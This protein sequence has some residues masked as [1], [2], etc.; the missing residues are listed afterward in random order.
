MSGVVA[1][2]VL[3]AAPVFAQGT[4]QP[5]AQRDLMVLREWLGGRYDS[6]EQAY[7]EGR[8]RREG[9]NETHAVANPRR[10][11]TLT[12]RAG[13]TVADVTADGR[14]QVWGFAVD[15]TDRTATRLSRRDAAGKP[16]GCDI[17]IRRQAG[18]F[19]GLTEPG[20]KTP[21]GIAIAQNA[22]WSGPGT[23]PAAWT[24]MLKG[25]GFTCYVDVP[26]VGG[27]RAIPFK[28]YG[29]FRIDD[30]GGAA[31]FIT[32]ETPPRALTLRLR[33]VA[34]AYNNAPGVFTRNSLTMYVGEKQPDG[35]SAEIA[36]VFGE[37]QAQ[38]IG[39][40]LKQLLANCAVVPLSEAKP[41]F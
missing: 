33:N 12:M 15:A 11:L 21:G 17:L 10:A 16:L 36:Y 13:E 35:T 8:Q 6:I 29:P 28:R 18:Q 9:G 30:Q 41:E 4:D 19:S 7:F 34:W 24:R 5:P 37:P 3:A 25:R 32:Q 27:G 26:G 20:C 1:L 38:R 31:T 2:I 23:D 22:I 40:N 14:A 39:M